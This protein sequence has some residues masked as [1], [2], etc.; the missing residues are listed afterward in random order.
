[1]EVNL[2]GTAIFSAGTRPAIKRVDQ[3]EWDFHRD[4]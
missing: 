2:R 1:M 3:I 4:L